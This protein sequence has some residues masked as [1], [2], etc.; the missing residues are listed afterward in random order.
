MDAALEDCF[1]AQQ[2]SAQWAFV[3]PML[4]EAMGGS[5]GDRELK[6]L[7]RSAGSAMG[8]AA[9]E[10]FPGVET[11]AELEDALNAFW[12]VRRWGRVALDERK[13]HMDITHHAAPLAAAFGE[14]S[15]VW[16]CGLLEG[17]YE[18]VLHALGAGDELAVVAESSDREGLVLRF[19]FG[20]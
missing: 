1:R 13:G 2:V 19:R 18:A 20:R 6:A 17:F 14:G 9:A 11:M 10:T 7:F 8:E 4:A 16:T 5:A 12:Q 15:L 3:L